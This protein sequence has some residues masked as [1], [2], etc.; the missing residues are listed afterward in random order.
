M[1]AFTCAR[2][3]SG[4]TRH[5]SKCRPWRA[6]HEPCDACGVN[7][8]PDHVRVRARANYCRVQPRSYSQYA[9]ERAPHYFPDHVR[10]RERAQLLPRSTVFPITV[11]IRVRTLLCSWSCP[12][13]SVRLR[14]TFECSLRYVPNHV[15]RSSARA[16]I[17]SFNRI[18]NHSEHSSARLVMFL[19][20]SAFERA[21]N[22]CRVPDH[23]AHS[24][25]RRSMF[26]ASLD[27]RAFGRVDVL[28][29]LDSP[30]LMPVSQPTGRRRPKSCPSE[31]TTS[32]REPNPSWVA[33]T[34]RSKTRCGWGRTTCSAW[35]SSRT[36][37]ARGIYCTCAARG[38]SSAAPTSSAA[39]WRRSGTTWRRRTTTTSRTS[40]PPSSTTTR[41]VASG[42][43]WCW[44]VSHCSRQCIVDGIYNGNRTEWSPI[45]SVI[46]RVT[47][48]NQESNLLITS[49]I[50]DRHRTTRS[51]ITKYYNCVRLR[52]SVQWM[53]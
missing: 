20:T 30:P 44:L 34:T 43:R 27:T 50:T 48:T 19:I 46:I 2:R 6:P 29:A 39:W 35:W 42:S 49:M 5:S 7:C 52:P 21:P 3:S 15:A 47:T 16:N 4:C 25:A 32:A 14:C 38:S 51:P 9:F 12:R 1:T 28:L 41:C 40:R 53:L 8:V 22:Y 11:R 33:C 13:S 45:R 36:S 24:S 31:W 23:D 17:A 10:V 18:P 37:T 26:A